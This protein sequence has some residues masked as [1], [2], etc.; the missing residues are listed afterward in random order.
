VSTDGSLQDSRA[1]DLALVARL[2]HEGF[3]RGDVSVVDELFAPDFV[4]HQFGMAGR[5]AEAI[6]RVKAAI[7]DLHRWIPDLSYT[8]EDAVW[9][10]G[11]VWLRMTGRGTNEG[12]VMGQPPTH[13]PVAVDV[14]DVVR[15][16][17]GRIVE[18][19]GVP[20]RF[21]LLAQVGLLE[22][23]AAPRP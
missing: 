18:H 23:L 8:I 20:D 19:W 12:P 5:G 11:T 14:I 4:E 1:D 15:V 22:R 6:A 7:S 17:D 9:H 13:R 3:G 2:V 10:D 16:R 21:A